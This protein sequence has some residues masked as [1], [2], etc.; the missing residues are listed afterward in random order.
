MP[1][2]IIMFPVLLLLLASLAASGAAFKK[3][4]DDTKSMRTPDVVYVGTPYDVVSRMLKM[5]QIKKSDLV[6]DLGCGDGRILVLAAQKYGCRGVGY[7]I[8]PVRV[9]ES[10]ENVARNKVEKL[11][12]IVQADIFT[13][14]LRKA[15]V[16]PLYLLPEMNRRL[17]PQLDTLKPGSR[18]VCHNYDLEEIVADEVVTMTSNEDHSSHTLSLYTTPLKRKNS[19]K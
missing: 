4:E 8:D 15:D 6:Y 3:D 10:R 7:D 16:I 13:L 18:V 9:R 14:D 12:K 2:K 17:L 11:V 19:G 5:A 1:K